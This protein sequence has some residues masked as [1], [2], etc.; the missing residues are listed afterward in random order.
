M[1]SSD[2]TFCPILGI[3][4]ATCCI[5][6]WSMLSKCQAPR[7]HVLAVRAIECG[8]YL[9]TKIQNGNRPDRPAIVRIWHCPKR[10][11]LLLCTPSGTG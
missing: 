6:L 10:Q 9:D 2:T 1:Q 4:T 11:E 7:P 5:V 3:T 8:I